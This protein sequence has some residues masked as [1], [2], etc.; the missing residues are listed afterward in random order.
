M[1][2]NDKPGMKA[3]IDKIQDAG[4][5]TMSRG[6]T[7]GLNEL[8]RW[9]IPNAIKRMILLTYGVTYGDTDR[10]RQ[11]ARDA[12]AAGISINTL[13]IGSDWDE[14]LLDDIGQLS[15]GM[16]AE[17][18]RS[19]ADAMTIFEQQVQN[20]LNLWLPLKNPSQMPALM[21]L[22][23]SKVT[24]VHEALSSLHYVHFARFFLMD[25]TTDLQGVPLAPRLVF[26][27]DV[28]GPAEWFLRDLVNLAGPG[29][30]RIFANCE[31]YAG[32]D[33]RCNSNRA[34]LLVQGRAAPVI[35]RVS[36]DLTTIDLGR[37]RLDTESV[38]IA[39]LIGE[40]VESFKP[41]DEII[42]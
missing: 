29:L 17:F 11:L 6:M 23:Q 22:L 14:S 21:A 9:D 5:T 12:A 27:A 8:H 38:H 42:D 4:G 35:G 20:A 26:L 13:G 40:I 24:P 2:A 19:T 37:L 32:G 33:P 30:D 15:G 1:S 41:I 34:V 28:D 7:L 18:I 36:M 25:A 31:D 16:P 10:C 3:A 39:A